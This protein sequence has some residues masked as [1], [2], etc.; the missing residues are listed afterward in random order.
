MGFRLDKA[1]VAGREEAEGVKKGPAAQISSGLP[2]P[3]CVAPPLAW[4]THPH[5]TR[6]CSTDDSQP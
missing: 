6:R 3:E 1:W 4:Q 5:V 2:S